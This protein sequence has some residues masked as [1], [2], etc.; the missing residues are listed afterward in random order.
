MQSK[1]KRSSKPRKTDGDP[2]LAEALQALYL[3]M[4]DNDAKTGSVEGVIYV[5]QKL[6]DA[7][8]HSP[9]YGDAFAFAGT[10][11]TYHNR[12]VVG[13]SDRDEWFHFGGSQ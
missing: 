6:I 1:P 10:G 12:P 3:G 9:R 5:H 4:R 7:V 8:R 11:V 2:N 13:F